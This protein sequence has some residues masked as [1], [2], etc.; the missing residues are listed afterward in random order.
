MMSDG[1]ESPV[2]NL[3]RGERVM[4]G[5]WRLRMP[6]PRG[7]PNCNAWAIAG[8]GG[9]ILVDCGMHSDMSASTLELAMDDCE[10][11]IE[12]VQ[13]LVCTHAH[14]DH[15]GGASEVLRRSG[16]ELW[17]HPAYV[18]NVPWGGAEVRRT[19]GAVTV[20][21]GVPEHLVDGWQRF[22]AADRVH[23]GQGVVPTGSLSHGAEIATH[24][25]IW[26]VVETP[27]HTPSHVCLF[28]REHRLL[29][30]G[31]HVMGKVS[32]FFEFGPSPDPVGE[33]LR[34]LDE[35][36]ALRPRLGLPGHGRTFTN[37]A[38]LVD[39]NRRLVRATLADVADS[40]RGGPLSGFEVMQRIYGPPPDVIATYW[41]MN[42]TLS[43]LRHLEILERV[44]AVPGEIRRWAPGR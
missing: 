16:C 4:D 39:A 22:H 33:F 40:L 11:A 21:H 9:L 32:V 35:V 34:S 8:D 7:V 5:L 43:Y 36:D 6:L 30:T 38:A 29:F 24:L 25:G 20:E 23:F 42:T 37:V 18:D 3:P 14:A 1:R 26:H 2:R 44:G 12:D 13:L 15:L 31:D 19:R 17:V 10:L 41:R 28:Q 27:G